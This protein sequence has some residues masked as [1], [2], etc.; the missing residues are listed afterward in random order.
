MPCSHK[1]SIYLITYTNSS[2][3]SIFLSLCS[4]NVIKTTQSFLLSHVCLSMCFVNG[5][6]LGG[7]LNS[8][9]IQLIFF[10]STIQINDNYFHIYCCLVAKLYLTLCDPMG[11]SPPSSSVYGISQ[12][13]I[14]ECVA[15]SFCRGSFWPKDQTHVFCIVR[16]IL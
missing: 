12:A 16:W 10:Y 11:C 14:M 3:A 5:D 9:L 2:L 4:L 8:S 6:K 13:R 15:I 7:C 1:S